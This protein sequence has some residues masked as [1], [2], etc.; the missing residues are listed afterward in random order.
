MLFYI[1]Q[2]ARWKLNQGIKFS[3]GD[4]QSDSFILSIVRHHIIWNITTER[5]ME[6]ARVLNLEGWHQTVPTS[7]I[8]EF[9]P[10]SETLFTIQLTYNETCRAVKI[11][12][13]YKTVWILNFIFRNIK[14]RIIINTN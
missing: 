10:L 6:T 9:M 12:I 1:I 4:T 8:T 13:N 5:T 7:T 3:Y 2:Y 11:P 14:R